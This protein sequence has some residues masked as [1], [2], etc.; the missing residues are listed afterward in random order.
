MCTICSIDYFYDRTIYGKKRNY[1]C[2]TAR[3]VAPC[4]DVYGGLPRN[5]AGDSRVRL[6]F[7]LVNSALSCNS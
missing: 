6:L 3:M 5:E 1:L 4:I 7:H 2:D